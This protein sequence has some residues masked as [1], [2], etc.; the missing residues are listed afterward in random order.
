MSTTIDNRV[1][2]MQFDNRQFERNV[3]TSMSTLDKLKQ[4][5]NLS[6]AAKGLESVGSAAK[7]INLSPLG[8]AAETVGLKFNA[9][10]TIADQALRN[11]TNSAVNA[12]KRIVS[13]LTVDPI[14]TGFQEYE[15][16]INAIQ[17]I[18]SNTR[19]KGSTLEDVNTALDE[20]NTY[21]DKTIYNFTEMTRNIGTFT[22]AGVD[23]DTS[24]NSIKGIA[25]LAAVSGSTSQQ[26]STA[27]YQLSQ[28]L[29]A[30]KVQLMDWNSV[31]NAG[32][33][34]QVFQDALKRTAK[35]LGYNVDAMIKKYG[36]FRES[37]T[38]GQWLTS[39]VL[40]ETLSQLSGAYSE[41]DLLAKGYTQEQTKEILALA[42]D[43]VNAATKVKTFTQLW[44]TLKE[45]AQSGWTQTWEII[46]GDF[47]EARATLTKVSDVIGEIIGASAEA[48]NALLQGWK[49][50]GGRED[51]IQSFKNIFSAIQR[52][53][54][55]I[56]DAFRE[57]FPPVTV[58]QLVK[59]TE[60]LRNLT[61]NMKLSGS[62]L[63]SVKMIFKGFFA[64]V[65]I[66]RMAFVAVWDAI[67][68][69][70]GEVGSLGNGLLSVGERVGRWIIALRDSV[71]ES[72]IFNKSLQTVSEFIQNVVE[73]V[74][75][76]VDAFKGNTATLD[77]ME[78]IH[79]LLERVSFRLS[80]VKDAAVV[81]KD[82]V[83]S[84]FK[85]LGDF[86]EG[87]SFFKV[88]E[89]LWNGLMTIGIGI[90]KALGTLTG[91]LFDKLT[92]GSFVGFFD[93][94][95]T[96]IAGGI[97]VGIVKFLDSVTGTITSFKDVAGN[98]VDI[99]DG[100]RGCFEA[101]QS[102]LKAKVLMEIAK[103]IA[104][105]VA[106][107]LVVSLI[108]SEKLSQSLG[109]ITLLFAD[110]MGS[111]AI[112]GKISGTFKGVI[113]ACTA[114]TTLASALLI[115]AVALK[116]LST[117]SWQ[118]MGVGL[119]SLVVGL[120]ALVGAVNLLPDTKVNKAASAIKKMSA[121]MVVL[122]VA[123]KILSTMSWKEM[124]VGLISMVVGLGSLVGA[125]NLLPK[126]TSARATGMIALA[127]AMVI[128]GAAIK[129]MGSMSW[130]EM[131]VGLITLA[132]S[133]GAIVVAMNSMKGALSGAAAML[134]I[135]P[136]LLVL[137]GALRIMGDMSLDAVTKS[138]IALSGSLMIMVV[139]LHAMKSALPGAAAM[140]VMSAALAIF[141]PQLVILGKMSLAEIGKSLLVLAGAFV[142]IGAAGLLMAPLVPTLIGL[143][144]AFALIGV[145]AMAFGV[146]VTL[147][148]TGL[149]A[150]GVALSTGSAS[151]MSAL[152]II[153]LG[154]A[155]LIPAIAI[156]LAEGVV[157]FA[158]VIADGAPIIGKAVK[159]LVLATLDVLV[160]CV[161]AIA[162]GALKLVIGVLEALVKYTPTVIDLL[163]DFLV[164]ALK[165]LADRVPDLI[166]V[167]F[168]VIMSVFVGVT[169]ALSS[170]DTSVMLKGIIGIGI[171]SGIMAA[172]SAV[173]SLV[174]GAMVGILGIVAVIAELA[175]V[176]AAI[177]GLAQIPG[178]DWL[179]GEG[180]DLLQSI[181]SAIGQFVGGIVGGIAEG[182][183]STLPQIGTHL[184]NFITNAT[185]FIEGVKMV[186]DKVLES[187]VL[188]AGA[189]IA[190]TAADLLAGITSFITGGASF[191]E[192]GTQLAGLGT[193]LNQFATNLGSFDEAKVTT[194]NCAARA[195][196]ALADVAN[197]LPNEGGWAAAILGD[198]SIATF[199]SYLP[200]LGTHLS[201]FAGNLGTFTEAQVVTIT[202]AANAIKAIADAASG[203]PNEGG[204]AAAILGDNSIA[205]FASR[206][207]TVGT[208]LNKFA[209][210]L[211]TFSDAQVATI[212]CAANA[213]TVLA[214][215]SEG[216]DGQAGWAKVLFGDNGISA[217][218][219]EMP[220]LGSNLSGFAKNLG[221]FNAEKV[222]TV[223]SSVQAINALSGLAK[224][225]LKSAKKN[226]EGFGEKIVD[227]ASD[228]K[229][230]VEKMPSGEKITA[231]TSNLK[232]IMAVISD[233]A[234]ID[235]ASAT[236]FVTSLKDIGTTGVDAFVNVFTSETSKTSVKNAAVALINKTI[237]GFKSR[238]EA[239]KQACRHIADGAAAAAGEK[240][241]SFYSVGYNLVLGMA[242]GI[243][244]NSYI[245][246]AK[247]RAMAAAAVTA[248]KAALDINSPSK[249]FREIGTSIPEGFA[250]GIEKFGGVVDSAAVK[251]AKGSVNAVSDSISRISE[252]LNG[253]MDSQLTIRPVLDLSNIEAGARSINN[254]FGSGV[255]V[256]TL[257]NVNAISSSMNRRNQNGDN[258]EVVH[259]IDRLRRE[260]STMDR[261]SYN[262]NGITYDSGSEVSEAIE[263]LV[264]HAKIERRT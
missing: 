81:M 62:Q 53:V 178:L 223:Q 195:V 183:V 52:V 4:S 122:A 212:D 121:S 84:A 110:L 44:D 38:K 168:D 217:F 107:I 221:T 184:S 67:K 83:V 113:K 189:I 216:I 192:F 25:N 186:D 115:L 114:I 41:A 237:E 10:Y 90:G 29:A 134:I 258:F 206:L 263:T 70:I 219:S 146:G 95:N 193:S 128:L 196:K 233:A 33:G 151:I 159:E 210:N 5:L 201:Q 157:R 179:I 66:G 20:L 155:D 77:W 127:S 21:A 73:K 256:G 56:K 239:I 181:G 87:C 247:A 97:G 63:R 156:K 58:E 182:A 142:V 65:D 148:A 257:A 100:V 36:S 78:P 150:L 6:G 18:L 197:T 144:G 8:V 22:A 31:V 59:F 93:T 242:N 2:E 163:F 48:R 96:I 109:A 187:A 47:E 175:L 203:L 40:T 1:V 245:V 112:F 261:P 9:L 46:V 235:A 71:K 37:L 101:Y 74:K 177:G 208:N 43:A 119:I 254:M 164:G 253:D 229:S 50:D 222:A 251:M 232:K 105:L 35:N 103:A 16:Q 154:I 94:L 240:K 188:L 167:A 236:R 111:M 166:Q 34:G 161:P 173:A 228:I 227:F 198:N 255:S 138:L 57:I 190:I 170:M 149:T 191:S 141:T 120:G 92:S 28:A 7:G 91:G 135:A 72:D 244:E 194:I 80:D 61:E 129:I 205:D 86:L 108:D 207:P 82:G 145:G 209:G 32:M 75:Y 213:I 3:E 231:A 60:G 17:T 176:L 241:T 106:A 118:E 89:T 158:Q 11:I 260:V 152:G 200:G 79:N 45:S 214:K 162:D 172:L 99:F 13:A 140:V 117:M 104:I 23:L 249:V 124:G 230:F 137:A 169:E 153:V 102:S 125:V 147:I 24:V 224:A 259:A 199:G 64:L 116:I 171:M 123:I 174:P 126:N 185:P 30:G 160:E 202:C 19:S 68:P 211:G 248:A 180:G 39:E 243:S 88:I 54:R 26:A 139:A 132:V 226:I 246:T 215:A 69:L 225:D 250:Q 204:W 49:D 262:I 14:K 238:L 12:G 15:T 130:K 85:G 51:L 133:L 27:M 131:G 252:M 98:I 218:S 42:E 143:A 76:L 55:P 220:K 165:G 264:R 234:A 136:A